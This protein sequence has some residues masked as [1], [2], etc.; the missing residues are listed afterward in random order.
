[1]RPFFTFTIA[2][3]ILTAMSPTPPT[4]LTRFPAQR[5]PQ[6]RPPEPTTTATI[7]P[8]PTEIPSYPVCALENF[9]NCTF[10]L[11]DFTSGKVDAWRNTLKRPFDLEKMN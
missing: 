11:E 10:T 3:L 1:M 7:A 4:T 8:T 5:R 9:E 6:S 2:V